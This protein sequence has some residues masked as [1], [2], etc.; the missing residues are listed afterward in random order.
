M[1][2]RVSFSGDPVPEQMR[3]WRAMTFDHFDGQR[4]Q[5]DDAELQRQLPDTAYEGDYQVIAEPA[6]SAWLIA[7]TPVSR[8]TG[9]LKLFPD[10]T[11][12]APEPLQQRFTY[13][14]P[15]QG[16]TRETLS[17]A[18]RRRYLQVPEGNPRARAQVDQ[19]LAE[20]LTQ[21]QIL[22]AILQQYRQHFSYTLSPARLQGHRVDEFFFSTREGFCEHFASATGLML[23]MAGI[24][25]RLV[26]GYLGA[27]GTL[28][29]NIC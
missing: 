21:Q 9:G 24:P 12:R 10:G 18:D 17:T 23:R 4:W 28:T 15:L 1:A 7:L 22:A 27:N 20:G 26:G 5:I 19:W 8:G 13:N 6:S 11:V 29:V 25:T 16:D 3:Y 14:L 2:F